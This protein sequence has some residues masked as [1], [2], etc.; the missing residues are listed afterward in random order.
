MRARTWRNSESVMVFV[1]EER[2]NHKKH[3][4]HKNGAFLC[5]LC[6]LWL[7]PLLEPCGQLQPLNLI[8]E[9]DNFADDDDG[10]RL[11]TLSA[12]R[13]VT[14]SPDPA[15]LIGPRTIRNDRDRHRRR[16]VAGQKAL[17]NSAKASK[18]HQ[19][20][21]R[22]A[23]PYQSA[24]S[25]PLPRFEI[26]RTAARDHHEGM[27]VIAVGHR[28]PGICGHSDGAR[29]ARN[30][31]ERDSRLRKGA[32]FLG[33]PAEH[34]GIATFQAA[35]CFPFA[36]L[37]D[38]E[39]MD[40]LLLKILVA[41][42]FANV[43]DLGVQTRFIEQAHIDQTIVKHHVGIAQACDPAHRDKV[44]ISWSRADNVYRSRMLHVVLS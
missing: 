9:R 17:H 21:Y 42:F 27:R 31:F 14:K 7:L 6:F 41:G 23:G 4:R 22:S 3:K 5:L 16:A 1:T 12:V 37:L 20:H 29:Y 28:N 38:H 26:V 39:P 34:E 24:R 2:S 13:N 15:F 35:Y 33:T 30:N 18:S 32:G 36:R 43:D 25:E 44:R 19:H 8:P 10:R 11:Q 40:A